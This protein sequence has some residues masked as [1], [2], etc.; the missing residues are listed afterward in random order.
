MPAGSLTFNGMVVLQAA[1]LD[2]LMEEINALIVNNHEA[3][4]A[5]VRSYQPARAK[6]SA[7]SKAKSNANPPT[8]RQQWVE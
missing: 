6:Q 8:S 3:A 1:T 5:K 4:K 7:V 2:A